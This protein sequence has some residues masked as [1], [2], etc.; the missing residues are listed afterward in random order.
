MSAY[1]ELGTK[2]ELDLGGCLLIGNE[3]LS[4]GW[5]LEGVCLLGIRH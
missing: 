5:T 1:W 2:C 3:A 4:V